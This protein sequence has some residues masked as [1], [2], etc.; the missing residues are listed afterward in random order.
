MKPFL[1]LTT[2]AV[3]EVLHDEHALTDSKQVIRDAQGNL[4]ILMWAAKAGRSE[5]AEEC[6]RWRRIAEHLMQWLTAEGKIEAPKDTPKDITVDDIA[7]ACLQVVSAQSAFIKMGIEGGDYAPV[8]A[9]LEHAREK[10]RGA[11]SREV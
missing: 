5:H 6:Q 1:I 4:L 7:E 11:F 8:H 9:M 2:E 3:A 10:L